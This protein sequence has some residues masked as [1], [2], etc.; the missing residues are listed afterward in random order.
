MKIVEIKREQPCHWPPEDYMQY[1]FGLHKGLT[2]MLTPRIGIDVVFIYSKPNFRSTTK[3]LRRFWHN[4]RKTVSANDYQRVRCR[5]C[6][7]VVSNYEE[8]E[9][10]IKYFEESNKSF[11]GN[12]PIWGFK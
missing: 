8:G 9:A 5:V 10:W 2:K 12:S 11:V 6:Q 3:Q 4:Y 7:V 1:H